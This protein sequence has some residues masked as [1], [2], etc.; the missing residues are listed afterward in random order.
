M[1]ER[2]QF[3]KTLTHKQKIELAA[4]FRDLRSHRHWPLLLELLHAVKN[5]TR[6]LAFGFGPEQF[7]YWQGVVRGLEE[8]EALLDTIIAEA[9]ELVQN[10][11]RRAPVTP[12][13]RSLAD[14]GD[15]AF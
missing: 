13:R 10:A 11:D 9:D 12:R 3:E 6:E 7:Q 2:S 15:I 5:H 1:L 8:T 4:Q 14:E